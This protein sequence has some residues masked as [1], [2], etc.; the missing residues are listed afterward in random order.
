MRD[1]NRNGNRPSSRNT[2]L[3]IHM[4]VTKQKGPQ[5]DQNDIHDWLHRH[6]SFLNVLFPFRDNLPLTEQRQTLNWE[7]LTCLDDESRHQH[8]GISNRR[9][10]PR[11]FRRRGTIS[12]LNSSQNIFNRQI[13]IRPCHSEVFSSTPSLIK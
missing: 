5:L 9:H 7:L 13:N 1:H 6:N 4:L 10:C 2:A 3:R 12:R 11:I 8:V